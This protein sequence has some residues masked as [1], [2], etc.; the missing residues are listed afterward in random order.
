MLRA[1]R[2]RLAA[3]GCKPDAIAKF[4]PLQLVLIEQKHWY[5]IERDERTKLLC[6]PVWQVQCARP[7]GNTESTARWPLSGLL[8]SI[9]KLRAE[10]SELERQ[11]APALPSSAADVRRR[12]RWQ[13]ARNSFRHAG[14]AA[15]WTHDRQAVRLLGCKGT[16]PT[17]AAGS[18]PRK[19]D[20]G[21]T[22]HYS[23]SIH[24]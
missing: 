24:K 9:D 4:P 8:P 13:A 21:G 2:E 23:V 17:S 18:L 7:V 15:R 22:V 5:E 10:L 20:S 6:V 12:A 14:G 1:A 16:R 19:S 11:V 3:A